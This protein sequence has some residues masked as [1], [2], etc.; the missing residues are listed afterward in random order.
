M[1]RLTRGE[2]DVL[3]VFDL[4]GTNENDVTFAIGWCLSESPAFLR[5]VV[6]N[7]GANVAAPAK[8]H[9]RLQRYDRDDERIGI[10]DIEIAS[11]EVHLIIEAKCGWSLPTV[12]QMGKYASI[13]RRSKAADRRLVVMTRW[14]TESLAVIEDSLG[15]AV[16]GFP[17]VTLGI[18]DVVRAAKGAQTEEAGRRPRLFLAELVSYLEGA[19]YMPSSH[20][21]TRVHVVALSAKISEKKI[22]YEQ[23]PYELSVYWYPEKAPWPKVPPNY[24]GFRFHGKLQSV[25]HVEKVT[26][27]GAFSEI[28]PDT[29]DDWGPGVLA[30]LG[31]PIRPEHPVR[32]GK[33]IPMSMHADV[34]IDLLLTCST[35]TEAFKKTKE[36]DAAAAKVA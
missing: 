7:C 36:R 34:D 15:S 12:K 2:R 8:V 14:G 23:V 18:T 19:G 4:L 17:L 27:F 9:I 13:L 32:T 5:R 3:T 10:T 20:R 30:T 6:S 22:P 16:D 35:V 25:H 29:T 21:D 33:G 28:F 1:A 24:F 11:T 31:P 26:H